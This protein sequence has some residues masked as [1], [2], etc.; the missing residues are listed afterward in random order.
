VTTNRSTWKRRERQAAAIFRARRQV[1]SGSSGRDDRSKSDSTH[2]SLFI[3]TK[4]RV[5]H[6]VDRYRACAR[7]ARVGLARTP[8]L[9]LIDAAGRQLRAVAPDELGAIV[10]G[11]DVYFG[12][13]TRQR[14]AV[15]GLFDRVRTQ[16]LLEGKMPVVAPA[17][18]RI[19]GFVL[20]LDP[21]DVPR[22]H[23]EF[24][25]ARRSRNHDLSPRSDR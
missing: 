3:E 25:R 11:Q 21:A 15:F 23:E 22:V 13:I 9:A 18:K 4:L 7:L 20:V 16:A 19:A 1:L 8:V 17:Q 12:S 24:D 6:P 2:E 10:H 14:Q 5:H